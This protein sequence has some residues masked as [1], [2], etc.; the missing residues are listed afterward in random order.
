MFEMSTKSKIQVLIYKIEDWDDYSVTGLYNIA[1]NLLIYPCS[2]DSLD[3]KGDYKGYN[4]DDEIDEVWIVVDADINRDKIIETKNKCLEG[5]N[6]NLILSNPCFEV[7]LYYHFS[8]IKLTLEMLNE[9]E[10][11]KPINKCSAWKRYLPKMHPGGFNSNDH[12]SLIKDAIINAEKNYEETDNFPDVATTQVFRLAKNICQLIQ[13][14][15]MER[16]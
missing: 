13:E 8:D 2:D 6:W 14:K 5:D 12:V 15:K 10:I 3:C 1:K 7:W 11:A 9:K 16:K 4:F